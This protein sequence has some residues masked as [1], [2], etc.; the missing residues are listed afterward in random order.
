MAH[1]L[2]IALLGGRAGG[3]RLLRRAV[4]QTSPHLDE[5]Q[6]VELTHHIA[7]KNM[8]DRTRVGQAGAA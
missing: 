2:A 8:R 7:L 6:I 3:E 5:G 1:S 4:R